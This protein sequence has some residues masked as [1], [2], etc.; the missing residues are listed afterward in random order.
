MKLNVLILIFDPNKLPNKTEIKVFS[1]TSSYLVTSH[2]FLIQ[3]NF[4]IK[5]KL[6]YFPKPV[7]IW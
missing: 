5:L 3:I 7:P 6:K 1:K 4:P 2:K